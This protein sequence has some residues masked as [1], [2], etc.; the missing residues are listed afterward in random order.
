MTNSKSL[1]YLNQFDIGHLP[2]GSLWEELICY[3]DFDI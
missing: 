3:L 1:I 2:L